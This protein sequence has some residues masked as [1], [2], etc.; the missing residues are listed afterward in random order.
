MNCLL[1]QGELRPGK[2]A[3]AIN[4][5]GYH[6]IIDDV[7]AWVCSQCGEPLFGE[8]QVNAIQQIVRKMD[9]EMPLLTQTAG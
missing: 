8:K 2:T 7:P 9:A 5:R 4:R 1:C 3:Y 6:L